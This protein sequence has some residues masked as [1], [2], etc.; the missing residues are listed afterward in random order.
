MFN[1]LSGSC[2]RLLSFV[3]VLCLQKLYHQTG[4]LNIGAHV[5]EVRW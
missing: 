1:S 2:V 4:V 5:F 3:Y